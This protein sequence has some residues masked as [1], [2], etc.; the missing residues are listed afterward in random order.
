MDSAIQF[1]KFVANLQGYDTLRR[2]ATEKHAKV[3]PQRETVFEVRVLKPALVDWCNAALKQAGFVHQLEHEPG[4]I[5]ASHFCKLDLLTYPKCV[6][7]DSALDEVPSDGAFY[8]GPGFDELKDEVRRL[9]P[10]FDRIDPSNAKQRKASYVHATCLS[11]WILLQALR[12][13]V[14][15]GCV[16]E[17]NPE[18]STTHACL[19]RKGASN[20]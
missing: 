20:E 17:L 9:L 12:V 4:E 2:A 8:H 18:I 3:G 16:C 11:C 19:W 14:P 10:V 13:E 15:K 7:C 5:V 1:H 6:L